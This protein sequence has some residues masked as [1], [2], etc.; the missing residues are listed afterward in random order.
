MT[1]K[2]L[3]FVRGDTFA[4]DFKFF[5]CGNLNLTINS[6]Y[7]S[8][9]R[10]DSD[11]DYIFQK[12]LGDGITELSELNYRVR[13]APEDTENVEPGKYRYDLQLGIGADIYT[14]ILGDLILVRDVT[15]GTP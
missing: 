4:F 15:E 3:K 12:K 5:D 1:Q 8:C 11:D 14:P 13:V 10:C 7:F 6:V 9:R 2:D